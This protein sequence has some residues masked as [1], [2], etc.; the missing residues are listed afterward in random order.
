MTFSNF[1]QSVFFLHLWNKNNDYACI[2]YFHNEIFSPK[3]FNF[4]LHVHVIYI[5]LKEWQKEEDTEIACLSVHTPNVKCWG[6]TRLKPGARNSFHVSH[7]GNRD[8]NVWA[9]YATFLSYQ[10]ESETEAEE[11]GV[12]GALRSGLQIAQAAMWLTRCTMTLIPLLSSIWWWGVE[13]IMSVSKLRGFRV[14]TNTK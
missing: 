11:L 14:C 1:L 5:Y 4:S 12:E 7:V 3:A 13:A 2:I 6:W 9:I 8:S 10:Q